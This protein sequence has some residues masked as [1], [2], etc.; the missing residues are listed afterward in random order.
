MTEVSTNVKDSFHNTFIFLVFSGIITFFSTFFVKNKKY[1]T[2]LHLETAICIVASIFYFIFLQKVETTDSIN[3]SSF[4]Q[5]R[6]ADWFFTT[7]MMLISLFLL[8]SINSNTVLNVS[9]MVLV[10][11]LNY[12]VLGTGYLGEMK[13]FPRIWMMLTGFIPFFI[14]CYILYSQFVKNSIINSWLLGVYIVLWSLYGI[15]YTLPEEQKNLMTNWLDLVSKGVVGVSIATFL[16]W[17]S[18]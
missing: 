12:I 5:I 9:T 18:L 7:P 15:V 16:C 13:Q 3:W 4:M 14:I 8:L 11:V 2:I 10:I 1:L 17:K 6:Y